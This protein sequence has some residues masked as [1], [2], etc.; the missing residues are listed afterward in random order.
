VS[1]WRACLLTIVALAAAP[2]NAAAAGGPQKIL[3]VDAEYLQSTM[4]LY[5]A[6]DKQAAALTN[7]ADD[8]RR[9]DIELARQI[10]VSDILTALPEVIAELA[11]ARQADL[12]LDRA[13]AKRIAVRVDADITADI[14]RRLM[15]QF[16]SRALDL[17]P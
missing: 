5:A 1:V 2:A 6:V 11:G 14:E 8:E 10:R 3:T 15:S 9:G 13:L 16:G 7:D 12:V 4:P 17:E